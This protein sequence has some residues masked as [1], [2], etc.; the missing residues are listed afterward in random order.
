MADLAPLLVTGGFTLLGSLGGVGITQHFTV[1]EARTNRAEQH[2]ARLRARLSTLTYESWS[3]IEASWQT[4]L[5]RRADLLVAPS[6]LLRGV[7]I[8][9]RAPATPE[10]S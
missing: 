5:K 9:T 1:R 8:S 3:L 10:A 7:R 6:E 2:K 4:I